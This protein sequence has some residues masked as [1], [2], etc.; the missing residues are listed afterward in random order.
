[1][2]TQR[3]LIDNLHGGKYYSAADTKI[4]NETASVPT[5]NVSPE[6]AFAILD[7]LMQQNQI[8]TQLHWKQ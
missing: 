1:M 8:Q 4:I 3:L 6:C 2:T 5:T 7:R